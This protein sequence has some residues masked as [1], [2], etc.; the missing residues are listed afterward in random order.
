[1]KTYRKEI[2]LTL[3]WSLL[4]AVCIGVPFTLIYREAC[5]YRQWNSQL[6]STNATVIGHDINLRGNK[7]FFSINISYLEKMQ[8]RISLELIGR[9]RFE[10][11]EYMKLRYP[12]GS[13]FTV[14]YNP[15]NPKEVRSEDDIIEVEKVLFYLAYMFLSFGIVLYI[16]LFS[17]VI[18]YFL[19][20]YRENCDIEK[21][22]LIKK[23]T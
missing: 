9:Q 22:I 17:V 12:I 13:K 6:K 21:A 5:Y 7:V 1:M 14:R 8:G 2:I 18:Y 3:E 19:H 4:V 10:N 20:I 16:M 15:K 23:S 11:A